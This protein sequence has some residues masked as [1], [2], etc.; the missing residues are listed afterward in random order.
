MKFKIIILAVFATF[1]ISVSAQNASSSAEQSNT[2][3]TPEKM[4]SDATDACNRFLQCLLSRQYDKLSDFLFI[5]G[6]EG[7]QAKEILKK[8]CSQEEASD[9]ERGYLK[10]GDITKV[11]SLKTSRGLPCVGIHVNV[12]YGNGYT[13][14]MFYKFALTKEGWKIIN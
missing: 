2:T 4:V 9:A 14:T 8:A 6:V 7:E 10:K 13:T 11:D 5:R 1:T 12:V 3:E